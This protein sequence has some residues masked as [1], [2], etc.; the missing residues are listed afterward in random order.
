MANSILQWNCRGLRANLDEVQRLTREFNPIV[1]CLQETFLNN[2]L[3]FRKYSHYSKFGP[4]DGRP[5]GGVSIFVN[6][7]SPHRHLNLNT[8]LQAV[9]ISVTLHRVITI[10]NIYIPPNAPLQHRDLEN[11]LRQ[12]P[13]P[14]LILGDLN[15]HNILWGSPD[16]NNRGDIIEDFL[17]DHQLCLLNDGSPTY[18]HPAS[19]TFSHLD[20]SIC[21]P[22]LR[23]DYDW[24]VHDDL[25]GSDHYPIILK[26][27]S[28][29]IDDHVP[30]WK[31]H[32]ANWIQFNSLALQELTMDMIQNSTDPLSY[33]SNAILEIAHVCIPKTSNNHSCK[34]FITEE[35]NNAIKAR[36]AA[37]RRFK[38]NPT[39]ENLESYRKLRAK[40]RRTVRSSKR[41]SWR[42]YV[43]KL[44]ASTSAKK[45]W[46]M[47]RRISGKSTN[48]QQIHLNSNNSIIENKTDMANTFSDTFQR[49]LSVLSP[50]RG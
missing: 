48:S 45:V 19:G 31:L 10:C 29:P 27:R 26:G 24:N 20:L 40:A 32:K 44:T 21:H 46:D 3:S 33:F 30:R 23:L 47:V 34:T 35:C 5:S 49:L 18:L 25:C 39:K 6:N 7:K 8:R 15:G 42:E 36:K 38:C 4:S 16:V 43:S 12:L 28:A 2:T 22:T 17:D 50:F 11:I 37:L 14:F 13:V 1:M 41:K 9:A